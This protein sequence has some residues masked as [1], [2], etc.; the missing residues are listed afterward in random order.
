M[1][2]TVKQLLAEDDDSVASTALGF[3]QSSAINMAIIVGCQ[4]LPLCSFATHDTWS[5][6]RLNLVL[7][8]TTS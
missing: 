3:I 1:W 4:R 5:G 2:W 8:I 6:M 7:P